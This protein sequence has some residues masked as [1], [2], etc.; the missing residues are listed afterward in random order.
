MDDVVDFSIFPPTAEMYFEIFENM[1]QGHIYLKDNSMLQLRKMFETIPF[2]D[3]SEY[4]CSLGLLLFEALSSENLDIKEKLILLGVLE[5]IALRGLLIGGFDGSNLAFIPFEKANIVQFLKNIVERTENQNDEISKQMR[6]RCLAVHSILTIHTGHSLQTYEE[7]IP[8]MLERISSQI[9]KKSICGTQEKGLAVLYC[10]AEKRANNLKLQE[11]NCLSCIIDALAPKQADSE[12][13]LS[14]PSAIALMYGFRVCYVAYGYDPK[15]KETFLKM[16]NF[17]EKIFKIIDSLLMNSFFETAY[18]REMSY[19]TCQKCFVTL[20]NFAG[21]QKQLHNN[22]YYSNDMFYRIKLATSMPVKDIQIASLVLC[23]TLSEGL[24]NCLSKG[25]FDYAQCERFFELVGAV[26]SVAM[27]GVSRT[28]IKRR[29][30]IVTNLLAKLHRL[31]LQEKL[32]AIQLQ[33]HKF[34]LLRLNLLDKMEEEGIDDILTAY[35]Q[36]F[37]TNIHLTSFSRIFDQSYF[38]D[39]Y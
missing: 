6:L 34:S 3:L 18:A 28:A 37:I 30:E 14:E 12:N 11:S 33:E 26:F 20:N 38:M 31:Y 10:I 32:T 2:E 7:L 5:D 1:L 19:S 17:E 21:H 8:I 22:I 23:E 27:N 24:C 15:I 29:F 39:D 36:T 9:E 16:L 4:L 35:Y 13:A 25:D